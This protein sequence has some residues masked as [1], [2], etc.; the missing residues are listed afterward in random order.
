M[1]RRMR[2]L[3]VSVQCGLRLLVWTPSTTSSPSVAL[4]SL[5]TPGI[6]SSSFFDLLSLFSFDQNACVSPMTE[7]AAD[8]LL[9][10]Y[11]LLQ[12]CCQLD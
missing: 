7:T 11:L 12:C 6:N 8:E 3:G 9:G 5:K 2:L 1:G 4:S 10:W